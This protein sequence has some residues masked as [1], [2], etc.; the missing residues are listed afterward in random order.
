MEKHSVIMLVDDSWDDLELMRV[1][2]RKAGV[3]NPVAEMHSG[4]QAISYLSGENGYADR[5]HFPLPCLI[6]TDLKMPGVDGFE[7]LEWLKTQPVLDRVPK[8]VLTGSNDVRDRKRADELGCS[9]CFVKPDQLDGLAALMRRMNE[10]WISK[11]CPVEP[12]K[13]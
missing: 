10:D 7:L 2:F 13:T 1:A 12:Q 9:A 11:F 5:R 8:I 6:I 4:E 3:K